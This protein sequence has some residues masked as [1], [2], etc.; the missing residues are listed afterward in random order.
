[1]AKLMNRETVWTAPAGHSV[2][3]G[4]NRTVTRRD[5]AGET[6]FDCR[7]HGHTVAVIACKGAS[8]IAYVTLDSCGYMTPTTVAAMKDFMGLFGITAGVSRAGGK[9]SV[10]Y[11]LPS[12][13]WRE[14]ED[15]SSLTFVGHRY[16]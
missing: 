8:G 12:G 10:R 4:N 11:K 14:K 13:A 2:T 3:V 6:F 15:D 7:L 16:A 1:M 5:G 9:L